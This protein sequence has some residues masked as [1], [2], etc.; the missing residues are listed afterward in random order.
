MSA[1][2]Q[3]IDALQDNAEAMSEVAGAISKMSPQITVNVPK[4]DW[5]TPDIKI[6]PPS[7]PPAEV[8]VELKPHSWIFKVTKRDRDGRIETLTATPS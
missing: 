3:I 1:E 4:P 5:R 7:N 8:R 6:T 2:Q